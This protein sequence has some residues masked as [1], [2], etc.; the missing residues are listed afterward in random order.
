MNSEKISTLPQ[1]HYC[2]TGY[3]TVKQVDAE[4]FVL[5][6][7]EG[8]LSAKKSFS[9][10][11]KPEINDTVMYSRNQ[12]GQNFILSILDRPGQGASTIEF[13]NDLHITST[14]GKVS[15]VARD[16]LRLVSA[17]NIEATAAETRLLSNRASINVGHTT[18]CGEQLDARID[19]INWISHSMQTIANTLTEKFE[20]SLRVVSGMDQR[21]CGEIVMTA[22][23]LFSL[24][25]RQTS[26][27][28]KDDVK[29]DAK[30]I[31]MG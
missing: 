18:A 23:N 7:L 6:H 19:R 13:E 21:K 10:L 1:Q 3:A 9:C 24:R 25:G 27:L 22:K 5:Q 8:S 31:H 2:E 4:H 16:D 14:N 30:R 15:I 26:I 11:L 29:I 17:E 28:A 20:Q 12:T